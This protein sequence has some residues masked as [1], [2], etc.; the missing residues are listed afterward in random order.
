MTSQSERTHEIL[1]VPG[2][3]PVR[4]W[5]V[6]VPFEEKAREQVRRV[7]SLPFVYKWVA[8]M[9]DV[10][11]G[12]GATVGS[13]I[14]TA[15]AVMPS[16]V[17]VDI[18]CGMMAVRTTLHASGLPGDRKALRDAIERG[19]RDDAAEGARYA[20]ARIVGHDQEHVRRALGRLDARR[21]IGL[22]LRGVTLDLAAKFE[23]RGG[24]LVALQG[25]R[26]AGRARDAVDLLGP[27]RRGR[28]EKGNQRKEFAAPEGHFDRSVCPDRGNTA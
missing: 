14:P 27:G 21:P 28:H 12:L 18:G 20:I 23:R 15:G 10:H 17:G 24:E 2:G 6:G 5:T 25:Y 13:V 26:G 7:A 4:S 8:V 19:R 9:P 22:G 11:A 16:A 1:D 3:V